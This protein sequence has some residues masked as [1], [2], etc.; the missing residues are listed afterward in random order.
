M[1]QHLKDKLKQHRVDW[2]KEELLPNLEAALSRKKDSSRRVWFFLILLLL[3]II[4][5]S[6]CTNLSK[7]LTNSAIVKDT[8]EN[9]EIQHPNTAQYPVTNIPDKANM[10]QEIIPGTGE[11]QA[12][13]D[14]PIDKIDLSLRDKNNTLISAVNP[15]TEKPHLKKYRTKIS[16]PEKVMGKVTESISSLGGKALNVQN[17]ATLFTKQAPINTA[18]KNSLSHANRK[19]DTKQPTKLAYLPVLKPALLRDFTPDLPTRQIRTPDINNE[20]TR[21]VTF[22][23]EPN[24]RVGLL[25]REFSTSYEEAE[26]YLEEKRQLEKPIA[27]DA[28]SLEVGALIKEKWSLQTGLEYQEMRERFK[29]DIL[30]NSDTTFIQF[31]RAY[32]ALDANMDTIYLSATRPTI[33]N[34]IR[35]IRYWN[36]HSY[37]SIPL[38]VSRRFQIDKT[39]LNASVGIS[40]ALRHNFVGQTK[41]GENLINDNEV[42]WLE[43]RLGFQLGIGAE[44]MIQDNKALFL[45]AALRKHPTLGF[46]INEVPIEKSHLSYSLGLG[47]RIQF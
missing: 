42:F 31:E 32:Y 46:S 20:K 14:K 41:R 44:Y 18:T 12:S 9:T 26:V 21:K 16:T 30:L 10:A 11:Y 7:N 25:Q 15:S 43:N 3:L 23:L 38:T 47:L 1:E 2:N 22:F 33:E 39:I 28:I 29:Y 4:S 24:Y 34:E 13:K 45:K 6:W 27:Y 36:K 35:K 17:Q 19:V 40:Y 5:F 8:K 37:I